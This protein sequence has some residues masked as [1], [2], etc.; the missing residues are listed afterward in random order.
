MVLT[1]RRLGGRSVMSLPSSRTRP[2]SGVSN[3]AQMRSNVV[4]PQPLGP[5]SEKISPCRIFSETPSSAFRS[6][7]L[8]DMFSNIRKSFIRPNQPQNF[9]RIGNQ[10]TRHGNP[11]IARFR[12]RG[13]SGP[14]R[15]EADPPGQ[16]LPGA[17]KNR[18]LGSS[19]RFGTIRC[20]GGAIDSALS[21][22]PYTPRSCPRH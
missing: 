12:G 3:P 13:G 8:L 17:K 16:A 1:F 5:S 14:I 4:F 2:E 21:F 19:G 6:P 7:K 9:A 18:P 22:P 20:Q 15:P 10:R 11:K